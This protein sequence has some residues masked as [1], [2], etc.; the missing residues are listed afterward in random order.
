MSIRTGVDS[1]YNFLPSPKPLPC[2]PLL[3]APLGQLTE[4]KESCLHPVEPADVIKSK[5][6]LGEAVGRCLRHSHRGGAWVCLVV[7]ERG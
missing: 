7:K 2:A 5:A 6:E 1:W 4:R 3:P